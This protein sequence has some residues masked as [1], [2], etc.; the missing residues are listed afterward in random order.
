MNAFARID[1]AAFYDFVQRQTE[2]RYE[3]VRGLIVQQMTGGTRVHGVV[4]RRI[5]RLI[6]DQVD[7]TKWTVIPERGVETS[8]TVRYPELVV[9]PSD[10]PAKSLSTLRPSLIVEVLSPSSTFTDLEV[11][12]AEYTSL[13]SLD[14]YIVA[15]QDEPACLVWQRQPDGRFSAEPQEI[16][17]RDKVLTARCGSMDVQ[18]PL[19]VIY[20]GIG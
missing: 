15:S 9:E 19:A 20:E 2:G 17:G 1:K 18:L 8:E 3:Y 7:L 16:E 6:E 12:P 14:T 5:T 4:A 11:K 10:E 13:S